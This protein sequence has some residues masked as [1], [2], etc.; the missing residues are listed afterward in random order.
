MSSKR[1]PKI[2]R[3]DHHKFSTAEW[4]ETNYRRGCC[5]ADKCAEEIASWLTYHCLLIQPLL[6]R[7]SVINNNRILRMLF[8]LLFMNQLEV[9]ITQVLSVRFHIHCCTR[10]YV[11]WFST[12]YNFQEISFTT[13]CSVIFFITPAN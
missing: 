13:T 10:S 6:R 9:A 5:F 2:N 3:L 1:Q 12:C 11:C 7:R 4:V 8:N